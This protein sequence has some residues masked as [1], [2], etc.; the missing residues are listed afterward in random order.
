MSDDIDPQ[1]VAETIAELVAETI[2]EAFRAG[3]LAG[4]MSSHER[5]SE[6]CDDEELQIHL[7]EVFAEAF[8]KYIN[9]DPEND[10]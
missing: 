9:H 7:A 1:L 8:P 10:Q 4:F 3:L 5:W 2:A 6:W